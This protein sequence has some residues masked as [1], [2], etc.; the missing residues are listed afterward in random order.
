MPY[1][2]LSRFNHLSDPRITNILRQLYEPLIP[3]LR[4]KVWKDVEGNRFKIKGRPMYTSPLKNQ[5]LILDVDSRPGYEDG[6]IG[7]PGRLNWRTT[8]RIS[9]GMLNH[10]LYGVCILQGYSSYEDSC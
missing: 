8:G 1:S 2:N 7:F 4:N 10:Y 6:E 3:S 5:V 9:A